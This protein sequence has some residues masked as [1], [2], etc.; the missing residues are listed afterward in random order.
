MILVGLH[1]QGY[2]GSFPGNIPVRFI[3]YFIPKHPFLP[4]DDNYLARLISI[5][6]GNH[7]IMDICFYSFVVRLPGKNIFPGILSIS[8]PVSADND[9]FPSIIVHVK[10]SCTQLF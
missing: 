4:A 1:I 7:N 2:C 8:V 9:I 10:G 5:Y 3:R 6:I